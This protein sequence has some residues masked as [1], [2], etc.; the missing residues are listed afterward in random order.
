MRL[1]SSIRDR[2]N[3]QLWKTLADLP[4]AGQR[5]RL[6]ALLVVPFG[7]NT[8]VLD[9]LRRGPTSITASGLLNALTGSPKFVPSM[10][11]RWMCLRYP[12]HGLALWPGTPA[13]RRPRQFLGWVSNVGS[14]HC[15]PLP[16]I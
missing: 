2:G 6:E 12:R 7:E 3:A 14:R 9:R 15:S 16:V 1:I 8:S 11:V 10:S 13:L 5:E 4:D